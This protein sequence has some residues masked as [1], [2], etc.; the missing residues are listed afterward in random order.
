MGLE[1]IGIDLNGEGKEL[2]IHLELRAETISFS[3][4]R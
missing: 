2:G 4:P 1:L 3:L